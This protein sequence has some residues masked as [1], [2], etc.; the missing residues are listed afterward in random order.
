MGFNQLCSLS[1]IQQVFIKH[2]TVLIFNFIFQIFSTII[3][4]GMKY[5]YYKRYLQKSTLKT[6]F[7]EYVKKITTFFDFQKDQK[8][9]YKQTVSTTRPA[10]GSNYCNSTI[11]SRSTFKKRQYKKS[12][13]IKYQELIVCTLQKGILILQNGSIRLICTTY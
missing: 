8:P 11:Y 13:L 6:E 5:Y 7:P 12:G 1:F 2:C 10:K 9:Q 3:Q 4:L